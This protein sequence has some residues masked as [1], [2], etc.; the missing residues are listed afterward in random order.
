MNHRFRLV[1]VK[2]A[3]LLAGL[4][5][6]VSRGNELTAEVL[7]HLAELEERRLHL[8]LGFPSLFAYCVEALGLSEGSAGRRVAAARVCRRFPE[9]F[10]LVARGDLHL[11]A[12][13][14]LAPHLNL[15]NSTE[16]FSACRRKTRR[17]VDELL[18]ARFPKPDV[19]DQIRRL[20]VRG[21]KPMVR[22]E[23]RTVERADS[24]ETG[25]AQA[26]VA[27]QGQNVSPSGMARIAQ[28]TA[29]IAQDHDDETAEARRAD[30]PPPSAPAPTPPTAPA[31]R[32]ELEALSADRYGVH[33][34]A[35]AELRELLERA[36][37]L[38]SHRLPKNDLPSL[39][40]LVLSSF[41]NHEEA[42]RFA[43]GRP[44]SRHPKGGTPRRAKAESMPEDASTSRATPRAAP[45]G[46][47]STAITSPGGK[48][49][50]DR[51]P[52]SQ[53]ARV[54]AAFVKRDKRSR[55]VPAAVRRAVYLRDDGRCSFVSQDG[56]RCGARASL[57]LDHAEPWAKL[58]DAGVD[59]IRLRCRAHNQWHARECFGAKHIEARTAARRS[60]AAPGCG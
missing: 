32:R 44:A 20:P 29:E 27:G 56:R 40:R 21:P 57:E 47:V 43:I 9:A 38:A 1:S 5:Q 3:E 4:S 16:L 54:A 22:D 7:A 18:A 23:L 24:Q 49:A 55:Y 19:Q 37:A 8:Q 36:R 12:L 58:G 45:P 33:F 39:M 46:G 13:C 42:R 52:E 50:L 31:R 25:L 14:G 28:E 11:S 59:N 51:S 30:G 10:E 34:T 60:A 15:Q 41:V 2:N 26:S 6:L 53:A 35:D 17:Q 48:T